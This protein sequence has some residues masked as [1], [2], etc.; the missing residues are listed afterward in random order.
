MLN[1]SPD[2][3]TQP[4]NGRWAWMKPRTGVAGRCRNKN[5]WFLTFD[6]YLVLLQYLDPYSNY[7]SL[8]ILVMETILEFV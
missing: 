4:K 3:Q 1:F 2:N 8:A 5:G 7:N 6:G